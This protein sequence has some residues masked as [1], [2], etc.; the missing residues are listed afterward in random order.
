[1]DLYVIYYKLC[2]FIFKTSILTHKQDIVCWYKIVLN[3]LKK[4]TEDFKTLIWDGM[5]PVSNWIRVRQVI[6]QNFVDDWKK[7]VPGTVL[8][9]RSIMEKKI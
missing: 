8:S 5:A 4:D 6:L 1:M 2:N 9:C 7:R 3:Y